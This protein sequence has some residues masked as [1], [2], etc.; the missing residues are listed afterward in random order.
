MLGTS[1][2][3]QAQMIY[4]QNNFVY[5][6][7]DGSSTKYY[8]WVQ[9]SNSSTT[10]LTEYTPTAENPTPQTPNYVTYKYDIDNIGTVRI[11]SPTSNITKDFLDVKSSSSGG[12]I[13]NTKTN[14]ISITADFI[15]NSVISSSNATH[16]GAIYNGARLSGTGAIENITGNF[17]ANHIS[18]ETNVAY[19]GA[20]YN[21]ANGRTGVIGNIKGDFV[22]NW[23]YSGT[24]TAYG[25]AITNF[26]STNATAIIKGISGNFIGNYTYSGS[27]SAYGGAIYNYAYASSSKPI[28]GETD[29]NG[30]LTGGIINSSFVNNYAIAP[31]GTAKG[32]AIWSNA[33]LSIIAKDEHTS[34]ISGNK[35]IDKNGT[36]S[37]AIYMPV[38]M[39]PVYQYDKF[40]ISAYIDTVQASTLQF[41]AES[42]GK[43]IVNDIIK[44]DTV[45]YVKDG[46]YLVAMG[47]PSSP[48]TEKHYI[49]SA[50]SIIYPEKSYAHNNLKLNGD[51]TSVIQLNNDVKNFDI[52]MN[53]VQVHLG[54]RDNVLDS[55]NLVLNSGT[56]NMVNN[57]TGVAAPLSLILNGEVDFIADVD[58]K[59]GVMDRF[60]AQ[61]YGT[62]TGN[63]NI[64]GMNM[65]ND[66]VDGVD[67]KEIQFAE[68]G[69]KNNVTLG[70][71]EMPT[72]H[73]TSFYTPIFK[74]NA[75]YDNRADAGYFIFTR[76][77]KIAAITPD[78]G[79]STGG[80]TGGGTIPTIP[81]G[82][83]SEAFNPTVLGSS[84]T[85]Q[86][87]A[88]GTMNQTFNYAFQNADNFMNI[89]SL[90]R[91]SIRNKNKYALSLTGDTTNS[92]VFSPLYSKQDSSSVWVKPYASF[93]N[94][95]LKNGPKV[96]NITYGT[97]IGFDSEMK[98]LKNGWDSV[99]TGYI[100][101]NGASQRY[102]GV[103]SYQNGG[104]LGG[105]MTLYK[106][107]FFNATTVSIGASVAQNNNMYGSEDFALLLSGI[108][109]KTGYNFEIKEG[110]IIIQPSMLMSY[111]FVN[112]FDYTNAAGVRIDNKPLHALQLA[113]GVKVIG[114]LKG[115]WQPYAS[116]SMVWNLMG[117]SDATANGIRLPQMSIKPYVQYGLGLQKRYK[118]HCMAF[119]QAMILNGG[120][121]G[122]SLTAGFR[123]ALGK[124][125]THNHWEHNKVQLNKK[126]LKSISSSVVK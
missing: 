84:T 110:K 60:E 120:R 74:Y 38:L 61:N 5:G 7:Q 87:G 39:T 10:T 19:G 17:V 21:Y 119:A 6:N 13:Y 2:P 43:I 24:S 81:S 11:Q 35:V 37:E 111:T 75:V 58:L 49:D 82:N 72:S 115:G 26:A 76:G 98:H 47:D 116:V 96:S 59:N 105:T 97:L 80:T 66:M 18:S 70:M 44:S 25:G 100:G 20:I 91:I 78:A 30:N 16:G 9:D 46:E 4:N 99:F 125:N 48:D 85:A 45:E 104:L 41:T 114:N 102:S 15:N 123:W 51:N 42:N 113:P 92:G 71:A 69:L 107:N 32:G 34:L 40:G 8:E 109:N 52:T 89:P 27:N 53:N 12:T 122:V 64:V 106:G 54:A 103:N 95:P 83:P 23:S 67:Q 22:G 29:A 126:V 86:A 31:N 121:N 118:C 65:L 101:Y 77:D 33:D 68:I 55:N 73:Q 112:T 28:I 1:A 124:G 88:M 94:I 3:A 56:F 117:E 93:E 63:L 62:H 79:G 108:G 50:G 14:N 36:R 90:E 57:Q